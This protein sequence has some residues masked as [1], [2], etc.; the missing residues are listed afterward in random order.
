[1]RRQDTAP[2]VPYWMMLADGRE[3]AIDHPDFASIPEQE[4]SV[5]VYDFSGG[6]EVVDLTLVVPL[7]Y[8][9]RFTMKRK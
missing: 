8:G 7:Q 6:V 1:M 4:E 2:F 5:T 9:G 3:I